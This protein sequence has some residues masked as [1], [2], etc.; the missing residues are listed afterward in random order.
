[1]VA[2]V[3]NCQRDINTLFQVCS[4]GGL[5]LN[6]SKCAVFKFTRNNIFWSGLGHDVCY[7]INNVAIPFEYSSTDLGVCIDNKLKFHQHVSNGV[8]KAGGVTTSILRS[9]CES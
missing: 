7:Y 6:P 1:M 5:A 8:H 2:A 9:T 4:L 3:E